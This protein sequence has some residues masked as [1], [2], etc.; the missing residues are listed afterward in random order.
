MSDF[1]S[2]ILSIFCLFSYTFRL[3][4]YIINIF[5]CR[6]PIVELTKVWGNRPRLNS[7]EGSTLGRCEHFHRSDL[8][9][10]EGLRL[11]GSIRPG[12][13]DTGKS[14]VFPSRSCREL[15]FSIPTMLVF[16]KNN[17]ATAEYVQ[18]KGRT[19]E[20]AGAERECNLRGC[21]RTIAPSRVVKYRTSCR[22]CSFIRNQETGVSISPEARRM[23]CV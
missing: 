3:R 12:S 14:S 4:S 19:V 22:K 7:L 13:K 20:Q 16:V 18:N 8:R 2:G 11:Q 21:S 15:A 9:V 17:E 23:R 5:F 6:Q 10:R 1:P